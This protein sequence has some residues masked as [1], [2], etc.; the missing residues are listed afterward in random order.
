MHSPVLANACDMQYNTH[1]TDKHTVPYVR[2]ET[3]RWERR[4]RGNYVK[5]KQSQGLCNFNFFMSNVHMSM[6]KTRMWE[7]VFRF[8]GQ[9]WSGNKL[10]WDIK[11]NVMYK[12]NTNTK[13]CIWVCNSLMTSWPPPIFMRIRHRAN[14]FFGSQK[15]HDLVAIKERKIMTMSHIRPKNSQPL[16]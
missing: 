7:T 11:N 4:E 2:G 9:E 1:S 3:D 13:L 12:H 10:P 6:E 5:I 8:K 14:W 16:H 15:S